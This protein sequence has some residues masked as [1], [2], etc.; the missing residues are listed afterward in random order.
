MSLVSSVARRPT[1]PRYA[2][3]FA[4]WLGLALLLSALGVLTP[5]RR[6]AIPLIIAG[7][8]GALLVAYRRDAGFR[9]LA[10]HV[11][12]RVVLALHAVRAL[13]GAAFL[14]LMR[15][16]RLAP[17]FAVVAGVGDIAAGAGALALMPLLGAETPVTGFRRRALAAWNTFALADILLVVFTAQRILL[18]RGDVEAMRGL[19]DFPGPVLPLFLVPLVL[20]T[21][22]LVFARLKA[23][24]PSA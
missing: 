3:S 12:L 5:E 7:A 9:G 4:I 10:D 21:H 16:G 14:V 6:F 13:A 18:V 23:R 15:A 24:A 1:W 8:F 11:D 20:A 19:L 2:W 22:V 17:E